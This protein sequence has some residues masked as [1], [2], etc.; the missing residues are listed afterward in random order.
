MCYTCVRECP[1]KAIRI[2]E[3]QAQVIG[4]RCIA[5]GNCVRVCSQS[6]KLLRSTA[7]EVQALLDADEDVAACLAPSFPAE[8]I[9]MDHTQMVG[10]LRALGFTP[11]VEVAF[12]ADLVARRYWELLLACNGHRYIST[13]CPAIINFVERYY[14][15]MVPFLAPIVSPMIATARA[16]R[17]IYDKKLKVVF[18]GPC[19]A[20]K[21]EAHDESVAGEIDGAITFS[22]LRELFAAAGIDAARVEPSDFDPPRGSAG[23][24][25]PI[26]RGVLQAANL[27][28]DLLTGEIVATQGRS[29]VLEAI[30]EF[31]DGDLGAKLLEVLCCEGCIMGAGVTNDLPMFSRR[32][33]VRTYV[34]QHMK[35]CDH[36]RWQHDMQEMSRLDLSRTFL[37]HDQRIPAPARSEVEEI[38][39]RMG[40]RFPAD[41]LNCGACGYDTCREH[42]IAIHKR[43]AETEMCLPHTIDQLRMALRE[44]ESSHVQLAAA[45]EALVQS[46]K[47]ASM[48]QL[49]AGIAHEVN[50]P[51]GVVLM[52]AHLLLDDCEP[53]SKMREDLVMIAEQADRC[54]KIVAGLL[55]FARQNK[56]VRISNDLREL[57]NRAML[58]IPVPG[59]ITVNVKHGLADPLAEVDRDQIVQVLTN[60]VSNAVA[61]M[62]SGGTLTIATEGDENHVCLIVHDTGVGIPPENIKKVFDPFFTTKQMGKG[63]GLGLAVTYGIVKM[64]GGDIRV[65]S[66]ADPAA[67][68]TGTNF[69]VTL[70]RK[71]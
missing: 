35:T 59:A 53:Q 4:E 15:E 30:K 65:Q 5:C 18:I 6:A 57:I 52:Y 29:H 21:M 12:G 20:K 23:G 61:A 56:V 25:F 67:G 60:L 11:V 51:L 14:P 24:L 33:R 42:A 1:V 17:D 64:H 31:A 13:T 3:G 55:H 36:E 46:E 54:K 26:S 22:E 43:L 45:Q 19:I 71:E 10:M 58:M 63:T 47:L 9:D 50:N 34:K 69:T 49:A 2:T 48:G 38:M 28:E 44:V 68:P 66:Q 39:H 7:H 40:K 37:P 16:L 41:E 62:E 27:R 70:P 32:R 8:F